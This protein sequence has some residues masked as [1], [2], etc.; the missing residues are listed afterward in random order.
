LIFVSRAKLQVPLFSYRLFSQ[1]ALSTV[2]GTV[3]FWAGNGVLTER[4]SARNHT[5]QD[6]AVDLRQSLY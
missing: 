1:T 3:N 6:L 4:H 5:V 2:S